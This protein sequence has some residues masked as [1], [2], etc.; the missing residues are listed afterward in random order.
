MAKI[1]IGLGD[2]ITGIGVYD[3]GSSYTVTSG[4]P[5]RVDGTSRHDGTDYANIAGTPVYAMTN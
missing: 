4:I 2:G 3:T 1:S 5:Y